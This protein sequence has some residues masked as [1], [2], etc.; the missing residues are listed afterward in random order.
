M[1]DT[2]NAPSVGLPHLSYLDGWRAVAIMGVLADHY[3][4]P[5]I[6]N[7]GRFGVEMFFAL[8][9]LLM[10]DILFVRQMALPKFFGRRIARVYPALFV[11]LSAMGLAAATGLWQ[12]D[13]PQLISAFT[14]TY[15]YY[16]IEVGR[17]ASIDH[18]WTLCVEEH[19]YVVLAIIAAISRRSQVTGGVVCLSLAALAW[20]NG[21]IQTLLG[22]DYYT[23]Y[24][25]TDV[26]AASILLAAGTYLLFRSHK[27]PSWAPLAF[28]V[29]G[30]FFNL[31]QIPDPLKY[32]V[33]TA[34][35]AL[36]VVYLRQAPVA[37]LRLLGSKPLAAIGILSFSIY[38]WQRPFAQ[39]P[40]I[41][42]RTLGLGA[43]IALSVLSYF[44]IER[45]AR[46]YLNKQFERMRSTSILRKA[47]IRMP[48]PATLIPRSP[49]PKSYSAFVSPRA[50][51]VS[52]PRRASRTR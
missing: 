40:G 18:I 21:A 48:P 30:V 13:R 44:F 49:P 2:A 33:G 9:G 17:S 32:G 14:F 26:R 1:S 8:S 25:R 19:T 7:P 42:G 15:N 37:F 27:V 39:F 38:L 51:P 16:D 34:L 45:P 3:L 43:A 36:A 29:A 31:E 22:G 35:L 5:R 28:G 47:D 4:A 46:R 10:A 6:I 20:S 52:S 23:V 12:I 41:A 24:W 11:F 50:G